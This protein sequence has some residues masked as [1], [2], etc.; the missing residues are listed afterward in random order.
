[1]EVVMLSVRQKVVI[2]GIM[3]PNVTYNVVGHPHKL[4]KRVKR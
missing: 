4:K 1:M 2:V 3:T